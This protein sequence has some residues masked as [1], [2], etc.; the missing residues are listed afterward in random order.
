M[1]PRAHRNRLS[2]LGEGHQALTYH[3]TLTDTGD[4]VTA[5]TAQSGASGLLCDVLICAAN[6]RGESCRIPM[7]CLRINVTLAEIG[8]KR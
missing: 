3:S 5:I 8:W 7:A 2:K 4:T 1:G 6:E